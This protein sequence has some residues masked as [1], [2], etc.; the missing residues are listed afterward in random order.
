M[1]QEAKYMSTYFW[2][3]NERTVRRVNNPGRKK[4]QSQRKKE[5]TPLKVKPVTR[6]TF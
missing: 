3:F 2:C 5:A 4:V 1:V 6:A